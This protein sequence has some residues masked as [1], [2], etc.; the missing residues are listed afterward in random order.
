MEWRKSSKSP[1]G[2]CV[3]VARAAGSDVVRVRDS[4]Q[5]GG[6]QLQFPVGSFD[7]LLRCPP[8]AP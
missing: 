3:E 1:S 4:K 8:T 6:A 7:A 5:P 2:G